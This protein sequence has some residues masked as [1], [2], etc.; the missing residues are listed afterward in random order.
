M[1]DVYEVQKVSS[2]IQK[3]E[4]E[5]YGESVDGEEVVTVAYFEHLLSKQGQSAGFTLD[6]NIVY[7]Y[8]LDMHGCT[9]SPLH[10]K[11]SAITMYYR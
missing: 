3:R 9:C 7:I 8:I 10:S 11:Y 6:F 5:G 4:S 1:A 2:T